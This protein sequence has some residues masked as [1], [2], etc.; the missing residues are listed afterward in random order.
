VIVRPLALGLLA[1]FLIP[2]ELLLGM[3]SPGF[4]F[5]AVLAGYLWFWQ[6]V[7]ATNRL[8]AFVVAAGA[9]F[10]VALISA[11]IFFFNSPDDAGMFVVGALGAALLSA[12]FLALLPG[13][14]DLERIRAEVMVCAGWGGTLGAIGWMMSE[15]L[16]GTAVHPFVGVVAIWQGGM[17]FALALVA[18]L[19]TVAVKRSAAV[20]IQAVRARLRAAVALTSA[21]LL[22]AWGIGMWSTSGAEFREVPALPGEPLTASFSEAP[23]KENLPRVPERPL[24]DVLILRDIGELAL[25][26]DGGVRREV[27]Q[28]QVLRPGQAP[29]PERLTYTATY[30]AGD[31]ASMAGVVTVTISQYPNS[32]WAR[33]E[34]RHV[35]WATLRAV[36]RHYVLATAREYHWY[37]DDKVLSVSG[38]ARGAPAVLNAYLEKHP[39]SVERFFPVFA[40]QANR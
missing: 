18:E 21:F 1:A 2:V 34:T 3:F 33:Y 14:R 20:A 30:R 10:V 25:A 24:D 32:D 38:D 35:T 15:E 17:A 11:F 36:E 7:R 23:S 22:A 4:V 27:A 26:G 12:A 40:P 13:D 37:S 28:Q 6:G 31:P 8:A 19:R 9:L 16:V 5:G 39:S 29:P